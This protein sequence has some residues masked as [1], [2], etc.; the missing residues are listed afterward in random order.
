MPIVHLCLILH[1]NPPDSI[2][3]PWSTC[4][5]IC[6]LWLSNGNLNTIPALQMQ[7]LLFRNSLQLFWISQ[8]VSESEAIDSTI[9]LNDKSLIIAS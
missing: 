6:V 9:Y 7:L 1:P 8:R 2:H 3:S 5:K 4:G